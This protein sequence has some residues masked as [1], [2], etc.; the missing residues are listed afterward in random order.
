[1]KNKLLLILF[2]FSLTIALA[3]NLYAQDNKQTKKDSL[4]KIYKEKYIDY[5]NV[6]DKTAETFVELFRTNRAS[7]HEIKKKIKDTEKY[8][9]NNPESSDINSKLDELVE[10]DKQIYELR[11]NYIDSLKKIMSPSQVALSLKF[12]KEFHDKFSKEVKEKRK[13]KKKNK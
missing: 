7:I 6:D 1:M 5:V 2:T 11:K 8:I 12:Q 4:M 13:N 10:L 3:L 9:L